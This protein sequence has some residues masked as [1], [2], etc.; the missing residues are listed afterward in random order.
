MICVNQQSRRAA[1]KRS[2][3]NGIDEGCFLYLVTGVHRGGEKELFP[4]LYLCNETF[5]FMNRV[6]VR[7]TSYEWA[8]YKNGV[9]ILNVC[10]ITFLASF[11]YLAMVA[12]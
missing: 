10:A 11:S 5:P 8:A 4:S 6:R 9:T 12:M 2:A 7:K 1:E 3:M